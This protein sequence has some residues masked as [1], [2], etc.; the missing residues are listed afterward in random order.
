MIDVYK[1]FNEIYDE[2]LPL[3]IIK[4]KE[5][6]SRQTRGSE[7]KL[8]RSETKS[9]TRKYFFKNRVV[10]F[11]DELPAKVKDAPS[12]ISFERHLD[13]YW[14][15]YNIRYSFDNCI[16]FEKMRCDPTYGRNRKEKH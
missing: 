12:I 3:P 4:A 1:M 2:D 15:K 9:D 13:K 6:H 16:E 14:R 10:P 11:W 8:H 7:F 5:I